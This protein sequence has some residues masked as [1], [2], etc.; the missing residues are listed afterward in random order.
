MAEFRAASCNARLEASNAVNE[1]I[2]NYAVDFGLEAGEAL[3]VYCRR[4]ALLEDTPKFPAD[5]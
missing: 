1:A 5:Y 4:R 2:H 3:R